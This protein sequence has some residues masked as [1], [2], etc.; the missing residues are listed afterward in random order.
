MLYTLKLFVKRI[1]HTL[2]RTFS[3]NTGQYPANRNP[4]EVCVEVQAKLV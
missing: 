1:A 4:D 3:L 2:R